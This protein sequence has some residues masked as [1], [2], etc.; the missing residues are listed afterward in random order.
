MEEEPTMGSYCRRTDGDQVTLRFQPANPV[1]F[2]I[3]GNVLAGL[4]ENQFDG[5]VNS[6]PWDHLS[7]F[8]KTCEIQKVLL[9]IGYA[10]Y[11]E[12][13][14]LLGRI[15]RINSLRAYERFKLLMR[16]C[17]NHNISDMEQMQIF[18]AG[19][20]MHH[21][22]I[23]D[24]STGGSIKN[25]TQAATKE[26]V[27]QMC[28]NEYNMS[29]DKVTKSGGKFEVNREI[30][31]KVEIE[32]LKKQL[33][34]A[35]KEVKSIR[36]EGLCDY[37]LEDHPVGQCL[38]GGPNSEEVNY[39]ENQRGNPY[40]TNQ[41][42]NRYPNQNQGGAPQPRKLSPLEE[43]LTKFVGRSQTNF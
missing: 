1:T 27:E 18:V 20:K 15:L 32:L 14:L 24:A 5:R 41:N 2:D 9:K 29:Q 40:P 7:Q 42:R 37:C 10:A 34:E 35:K 6:D 21:K 23:L 16:K 4:R 8:V 25:K 19:M 43:M 38:P 22:M 17:P 28:Q 30:A 39:M 12:G 36:N 3:K 11:P 13:R 33:S 26:L 31:L